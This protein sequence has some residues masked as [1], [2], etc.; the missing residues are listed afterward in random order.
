[1]DKRQVELIRKRYKD[2]RTINFVLQQHKNR[3]PPLRL[4]YYI[5]LC[6]EFNVTQYSIVYFSDPDF[7]KA[8]EQYKIET[9][10]YDTLFQ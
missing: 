5:V 6:F 3:C 2:Y 10:L 1:M 9:M 7:I 8:K 4:V